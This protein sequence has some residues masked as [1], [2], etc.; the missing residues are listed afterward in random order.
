MKNEEEDKRLERDTHR[1]RDT[2]YRTQ[3]KGS[4]FIG[5]D[6]C[7]GSKA[8]IFIFNHF[9]SI[10]LIIFYFKMFEESESCP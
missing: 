7:S 1:E 8:I 2:G 6:H 4:Q 3:K 10:F 5:G 9:L